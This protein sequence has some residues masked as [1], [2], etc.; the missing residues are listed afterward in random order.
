[1]Q[2]KLTLNNQVA[3]DI[4]KDM[5]GLFF[6]DINFA[7][8]GGLYAELLENRSFEAIK[9]TG[10]GRNYVLSEDNLYAWNSIQNKNENLQ[11][12]CNEPVSEKNPHYLRFTANNAGE[13]FYNKAYDGISLK[14]GMKYNVSFYAK[15]VDYLKGD[16]K[17]CVSKENKTYAESTVK[18]IIAQSEEPNG[19]D[20]MVGNCVA[21]TWKKY[22]TEL[23][24]TDD[25]QGARFEVIL[26][27]KGCVEF[28]LISMIP[29]DAVAGIFRKDL[30][31]ALKNI[32]PSFVRFPGGCI[33]E[34]TSL[35]RRYYWK[36]TV[37]ELKDRK[38]QTN[39]WALQGGNT[40]FAN[41]M[42][43]CHYMQS[44]GIGFYEYF[45]LCELLSSPNRK[46]RPL[47]VLNIGVAC[48]FRS[49]QTVSIDS[50]EFQEYVQDALDLIEFANGPVT[51]KWGKLRAQMGHPESFNLE[52]LA[53]GNEQWESKNV[54]VAPRYVAFEKA[55]HEV[56]PEIKCLG[57]AG[58]FVNHELHTKAWDFYKSE[59]A[60]NPNFTYAVDEHYYVA[61]NWL[62]ENVDF[63]DNYPRNIGIFAGEYAGHDEN[64]TNSV[65][66]ALAE[67]AMLTGME[68]NGDIVKLA[69]YAPLFNRIGHSQWT[70]DM[71][72]FDADNV[73]LTPSYYVQKL[74]SDYSGSQ[75]LELNGQEKELRKENLYVSAVKNND[76]III[77]IVNA[78][79]TEKELVL[80]SSD[81]DFVGKNAEVALLQAKD[82]K[83]IEPVVNGF[84]DP[85]GPNK[86]ISADK[87][88]NIELCKK[89]F[90]EEVDFT[91]ENKTLS[92]KIVIPAKSVLVLKL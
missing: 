55:I 26:T 16:I 83:Y 38:I 89:R 7:A 20:A 42:Q 11:I 13:G 59:C 44:Y 45:L 79:T 24:A 67:A 5:I 87:I 8:D 92:D 65:E 43:D 56:Y 19:Y 17:I 2:N 66:A 75:S 46:C 49:Y 88:S 80:E 70:P 37:G 51:S 15:E 63:Y 48:Q 62:Y 76:E 78:N 57:T 23:V 82:G 69:S 29:E 35:M 27:E 21:K 84:V 81:F 54:D 61:P 73:V 3:K 64:L 33:V 77:K 39:L 40:I 4:T 12:S 72:W 14:K 86:A 47:P 10:P 60:K 71:I 36:N 22:T 1:M 90:P 18:F 6:E 91:I 41:Q 53:I 85:N 30:F 68:K 32:N 52:L 50:P 25:I 34:G 28:D 9:S 58:P 31:E 74:F